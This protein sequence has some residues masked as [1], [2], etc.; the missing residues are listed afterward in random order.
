MK[1]FL[2]LI[3]FLMPPVLAYSISPTTF[4]GQEIALTGH[5]EKRGLYN[6]DDDTQEEVWVLFLDHPLDTL[7]TLQIGEEKKETGMIQ[8]VLLYLPDSLKQLLEQNLAEGKG[9][10]KVQGSIWY[11]DWWIESLP[12]LVLVKKIDPFQ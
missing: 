7:P 1:E 10:V 5:I 2:L 6:Q 3:L 11:S 12:F 9:H 4:Y 8:E